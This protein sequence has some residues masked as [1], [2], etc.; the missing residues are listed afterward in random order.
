MVSKVTAERSTNSLSK[1]RGLYEITDAENAQWEARRQQLNNLGTLSLF[2][3]QE[4]ESNED[5]I[6]SEQKFD[7][8]RPITPI[9]DSVKSAPKTYESLSKLIYRRIN[10]RPEWDHIS[11]EDQS[12]LG[13]VIMGEVNAVWPVLRRQVSDPFLTHQQNKELQRR[14]AVHCVT[15]CE[16]LFFHYAEKVKTLNSRGIFSNPANL[17]RI[18][19]QL[20]LD[21]G[22]Y[23]N[24]LSVR[25]HIISDLK[26]PPT[27]EV[28][29]FNRDEVIVSSPV[30]P[31]TT[32]SPRQQ[33]SFRDLVKSSRPRQKMKYQFNLKAEIQSMQSQMPTISRSK[34]QKL[35]PL[36]EQHFSLF[37]EEEDEDRVSE[38]GRESEMSEIAVEEKQEGLWIDEDDPILIS[39]IPIPPKHRCPSEPMV[40]HNLL[41][42]ELRQREEEEEEIAMKSP[43][44]MLPSRQRIHSVTPKM[45]TETHEKCKTS[46]GL[47]RVLHDDVGAY[48]QMDPKQ[49]LKLLMER[50][51]RERKKE[52]EDEQKRSIEA[53]TD[54]P[55]LI[56]ALTRREAQ[57]EKVQKLK[58][59]EKELDL[60]YEEELKERMKPLP[61]PLY[62][63]PAV[64]QTKLPG[65]SNP[66]DKSAITIRASDVKI[67]DHVDLSNVTLGS[68]KPVYNDL[69]GN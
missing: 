43:S 13:A 50:Q 66:V 6:A 27:K 23:L 29:T 9:N 59:R 18:R 40:Q 48:D 47:E 61:E 45:P 60:K 39:S 20:A 33:L 26:K 21:A 5:N 42:D 37:D 58:I 64:V 4:T 38:E 31:M 28:I 55:P 36:T 44:T 35:Q 68:Y 16:Q 3:H 52:K 1:T 8:E 30:T 19:A 17:S 63:Q 7:F 53:P 14:I 49:D 51:E 22:K 34:I 54:I 57:D 2:N 62:P 12:S 69:T 65:V 41:I 25:R 15:V 32:E 46:L 56:Q 11:E 67:N 10:P 24:I